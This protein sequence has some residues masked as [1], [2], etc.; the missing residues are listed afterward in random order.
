MTI[1]KSLL[2]LAGLTATALGQTAITVNTG[3]TY[4]TIDGFG[5]SQ[6]FG[7]ASQFQS[8][9]SALQKQA[10][11]FL[12]SKTTGAGFS[13]IRNR[14]GSG[15]SGDSIEPNN[16][17]S[18]SAAPTY[19]WDDNDSGQVWFSTQAK[20]YGVTTIYAD[21]WSA[22]GFMKTSGSDSTPGY[23]CG[24]PGHTCSSGDWRQ[25][26]ANFLVQYVKY[27]NSVGL[28]ITHLGFLNE[29]DYS[30]GY[31]QMQISSNAAEAISFIPILAATV[32]AAGLNLKIT[33]CDAVGWGTTVTYA[34]ALVNS[35][36]TQ[37]LGV[38]TSHDYSSDP[39]STL[40]VTSLP[41]WNTEGGPSDAFTTSWYVN[42]DQNEGMNWANRIANGIVTCSLSAFLFWEG[43][44][45]GQT[46]SGS[47]LVDVN[48][49]NAQ[50]SAIF[51]AFAMWSRYIRPGA[52]RVGTTGTIT[53]TVIGAFK[54]TDGSYV[55]VFTNSGTS[56][57]SAKVSFSGYTPGSASAWVT[58]SSGNFVTTSATLASGAVTV[59]LPGRSVVTV[60][61][62]GSGSASTTLQTSVT[63]AKST[64][65]SSKAVTTT[66]TAKVTTT[67][68]GSGCQSAQ[69]GQCGGIGWTGCSSC[70]SPFTCKVSNP[71]YSQCL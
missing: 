31:S 15:G 49:S 7:R 25:A 60:V 59:S 68:G 36:V 40:S 16:P 52:V 35:G 22:P 4:Q 51:W 38:I 20:N 62:K 70:V 54:N 63:T 6:A 66:T 44:E 39:T 14:I 65:T 61:L 46:Q 56:A 18:P 28:P 48:G 41:K 27:Y 58:S 1:P 53:S 19:V 13:I 69:Y 5:F 34:N 9:A 2:A 43:F 10:L 71:Y 24:T 29:P 30:P 42:G 17:G 8:T 45:N 47:H 64:T 21:A 3:T 32:K 11:D 67:G 50:P 33:C 37:Y 26:Y 57:Q 12:F 55:L 23:L